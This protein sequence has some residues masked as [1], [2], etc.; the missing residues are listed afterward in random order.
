MLDCR[1][2]GR[3]LPRLVSRA[4]QVF[5]RLGRVAAMPVVMR[6]LAEVI[7]E[8]LCEQCFERASD[9]LVEQFV[10][11]PALNVTKTPI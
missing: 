11:G 3:A 9:S 8:A 1:R 5:D 4:S 2:I 6:E 7:I 10:S